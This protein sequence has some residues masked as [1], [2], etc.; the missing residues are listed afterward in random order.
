M[1]EDSR[2]FAATDVAEHLRGIE[3]RLAAAWVGGDRSFIEQVLADD[4]SGIERPVNI[5]AQSRKSRSVSRTCS[6]TG[7]AVGESSLRKRP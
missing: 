4:W 6:R 7:T 1:T 2:S 5:R 3:I